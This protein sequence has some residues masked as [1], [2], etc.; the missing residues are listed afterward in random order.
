M[1][2]KA[3]PHSGVSPGVLTQNKP[4]IFLVCVSL[5]TVFG[6]AGTHATWWIVQLISLAALVA[7]AL[8]LAPQLSL[9]GAAALGFAFGLGWFCASV[10]WLYISMH[11]YGLLPSWMAAAG[12]LA[13]S[14]FLALFPAAAVA[15]WWWVSRR[16]L[17]SLLGIGAFACVWMLQEWLRSQLFT[18]FPW[19]ATGYGHVDSALSGYALLLG[20]DSVS[21]AAALFAALLG[22]SFYHILVGQYRD[23]WRI[24]FANIIILIVVYV[25]GIVL[26]S[27]TFSAPNA[28]SPQGI[29]VA[30]IQGNVPQDMK[31]EPEGIRR[32]IEQHLSMVAEARG[33]LIVTPETVIPLPAERLPEGMLLS[34][35]D[36]LR[37][38]ESA[39]LVGIVLS[40]SQGG[41]TNSALGFNLGVQAD[42]DTAMRTPKGQ[43]RTPAQYRYDK[44]HLVPFGELIPWG[45][46]WFVDMMRIPLGDFTRG[47][48][49]APSFEVK[50]ERIAPTICYEDV[51]GDE[52]RARF[53]DET[54]AP[55]MFANL[56]NLAW[57]GDTFAIDQH[58]AIARMRSIEFARPSVRATNTGATVVIN[59]EGHV[60][61]SLPRMS[62]G[63]LKANVQGR[64][65]LTPYARFGNTW[66][67]VASVLFLAWV[68]RRKLA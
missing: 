38:K 52:L 55:T 23:K 65:G 63:T 67:I 17:H 24:M 10:W 44:H 35:A 11:V 41:Y 22:Y 19:N 51:F 58:L 32:G 18:G 64:T 66:F 60:T 47:P 37:S 57:F 54:K 20:V 26:R 21:F 14:A 2:D 43:A 6:L 40:T 59:H 3:V 53:A 25:F 1:F 12:V 49:N 13:L 62:T 7:Y 50:G 28:A 15:L 68:I 34:L 36:T 46:R 45:F 4:F 48:V 29:Q 61:H 39:A 5:G 56:T 27:I 30:L 9:R 8:V 16:G 42:T 31:F 33:D